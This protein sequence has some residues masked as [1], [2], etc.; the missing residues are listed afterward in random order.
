MPVRASSRK[1]LRYDS[2]SRSSAPGSAFRAWV[3]SRSI[4]T[5]ELL[6]T[7]QSSL[8]ASYHAGHGPPP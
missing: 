6:G 5:L 3:I 4:S 2:R 8:L 1:K 7:P